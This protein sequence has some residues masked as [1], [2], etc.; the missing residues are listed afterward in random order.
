M[1]T[2]YRNKE[3]RARIFTR[4]R[5]ESAE[6]CFHRTRSTT[7]LLWFWLWVGDYACSIAEEEVLYCVCVAS[8][9]RNQNVHAPTTR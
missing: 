4:S 6:E 2:E 8:S 1:N 3:K 9:M 5:E 7:R